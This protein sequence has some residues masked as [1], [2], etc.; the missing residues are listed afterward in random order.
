M[1]SRNF[2]KDAPCL[3]KSET[4]PQLRPDEL[5]RL[6]AVFLG[7]KDAIESPMR[8]ALSMPSTSDRSKGVT[9]RQQ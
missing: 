2:E 5:E 4:L 1:S 6:V 7:R 8:Y 3:W 9:N